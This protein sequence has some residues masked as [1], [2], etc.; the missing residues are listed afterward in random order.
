MHRAST[1]ISEGGSAI[2]V[3]ILRVHA[4]V[5]QSMQQLMCMCRACSSACAEHAAGHAAG[6]CPMHRHACCVSD[7]IV[8]RTGPG[9]ALSYPALCML[10]PP[11]CLGPLVDLRSVSCHRPG[12]D[13]HMPSHATLGIDLHKMV[14]R[15]YRTPLQALSPLG[16]PQNIIELLAQGCASE[17]Q[18]GARPVSWCSGQGASPWRWS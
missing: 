14:L 18:I 3:R 11:H 16:S 1:T 12:I 13:L 17:H 15:L 2:H 4:R 7:I 6:P 5:M 10:L 9:P 8:S